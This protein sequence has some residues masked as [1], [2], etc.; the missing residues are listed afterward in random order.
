MA[1]FKERIEAELDNI[2]KILSRLPPLKI[3]Q[4]YPVLNWQVL[5][6]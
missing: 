6:R 3:F 4:T 2:Q 1:D 5:L